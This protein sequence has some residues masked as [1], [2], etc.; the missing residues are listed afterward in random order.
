MQNKKLYIVFALVIVVVAA[1]AFVGGRLLT[2][3]A[4][5][6]GTFQMGNGDR[7][8]V[9]IRLTPAPE[10]PTTQ[11][12]L[13]GLFV[14]RDDNTL[15]LQSMNSSKIKVVREN[16]DVDVSPADGAGPQVE[17]VITN[18]TKVWHDVTP[19]GEPQGSGEYG[20]QQQVEEG[21]LDD[22]NSNSMVMVWG[23]KNGDRVIADV[24]SY[25]NPVMF[26]RP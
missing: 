17:V 1:A 8:M 20:V 9:S 24:V 25:S 22:L 15:T 10:L 26:K 18:Q 2:G 11:A 21:T 14:K 6:L 19:M 4:G 23:R 12:D 16:D 5:P 3:Q 13:T 7:V